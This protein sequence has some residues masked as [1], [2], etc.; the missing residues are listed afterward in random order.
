MIDAGMK[1]TAKRLAEK[2]EEL[3]AAPEDIKLI[4]LT[5]GHYDHID[6]L[7]E[8]RK[9]TGAPVA[10]HESEIRPFDKLSLDSNE[11]SAVFRMMIRIISK[12]TPKEDSTA[13]K[14]DIL[15]TNDMELSKY[16]ADAKIIQTPGHSA[17]SICV[18]TD[19]GQCVCGDT[20]FDM[21]P[22]THYPII[23][24]S[25]KIL[26]DTYRKLDEINPSVYYPGHGKPITREKYKTRIMG[27]VKYFS[28]GDE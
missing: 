12:I 20:L 19:D 18:L 9:L 5:H 13:I 6:G 22:G 23:V 14:P 4:V 24:Y 8:V 15:I 28:S 27:R 2:L 25:R 10:V 16:G 26:A 1:G 17:G 7:D 11:S 3:G 21:F